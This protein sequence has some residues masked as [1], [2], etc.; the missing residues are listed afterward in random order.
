MYHL[1]FFI[2]YHP[3]FQNKIKSWLINRKKYHCAIIDEN[4]D[5]NLISI[6]DL[7]ESPSENRFYYFDEPWYNRYGKIW[8]I[9][10]DKHNYDKDNFPDLSITKKN[11]NYQ[12]SL[13]KIDY[14]L[15]WFAN[16]YRWS[17]LPWHNAIRFR[18]FVFI[19]KE[20]TLRDKFVYCSNNLIKIPFLNSQKTNLLI[21]QYSVFTK[22]SEFVNAIVFEENI[23]T[24]GVVWD[25]C[26]CSYCPPWLIT[27]N[28][29][30]EDSNLYEY[31]DKFQLINKIKDW[32][33]YQVSDKKTFTVISKSSI[34]RLSA[35]WISPNAN[36]QTL[37]SI[38]DRIEDIEISYSDL[39]Y[40]QDLL[41][42]CEW[43]YGFSRDAT[44]PDN[45]N[46]SLF[47]SRDSSIIKKIDN[48]RREGSY[49][50]NLNLHNYYY[51]LLMCF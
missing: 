19:S 15:A 32:N 1:A 3:F 30:H 48:S 4:L 49:D 6:K 18:S 31:S 16:K 36:L 22:F 17:I 29:L 33:V 10:G 40:L 24:T 8:Y 11:F 12:I 44:A 28:N 23:K 47:I 43:L 41:K 2:D 45:Y 14:L 25:V 26:N 42:A 9:Y 34:L 46:C 7:L 27:D 51:E 5:H 39:S 37:I 21:S 38:L 35:F 20:Q 13:E 50:I